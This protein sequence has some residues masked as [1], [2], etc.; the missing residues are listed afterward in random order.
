[1]H[2]AADALFLLYSL[3]WQAQDY[4]MLRKF[5]NGRR[6]SVCIKKII[7]KSSIFFTQGKIRTILWGPKEE[8]DG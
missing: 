4:C 6:G 7:Q 5:K 2:C 8:Q 1:L 3:D